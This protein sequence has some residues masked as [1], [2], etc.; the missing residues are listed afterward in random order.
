M[1][2]LYAVP[3]LPAVTIYQQD[4][5]PPHFVCIVRTFLDK[6]FPIRWIE[7]GSPYIAC[8]PRLPNPTPSDFPVNSVKPQM[9]H[10]TWVEVEYRL[11]NSRVTSESHVEVHGI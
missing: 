1:L 4:G 5:A 9:L 7:R 6:E 8:P 11:D 3:Q 2:Q 10:N